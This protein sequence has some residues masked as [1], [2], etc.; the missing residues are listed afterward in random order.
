MTNTAPEIQD[1]VAS[2]VVNSEITEIAPGQVVAGFPNNSTVLP[3][4]TFNIPFNGSIVQ[5]YQ[6]VRVPV[7][8]VLL[9]ALTAAG[10]PF[11][12]P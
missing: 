1:E 7:D 6:G 10:A 4:S 5:F 11:T 8:A 12:T 9:A 3:T 2:T